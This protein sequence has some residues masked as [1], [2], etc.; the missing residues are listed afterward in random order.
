MIIPGDQNDATRVVVG[1]TFV[2]F[3]DTV[4][5]AA[6][7]DELET[8]AIS[9]LG[10]AA[11]A[12]TTPSRTTGLV[13]GRVQS[14]KTLSYESVIA[15]ARDNGF[16]LVVVISGIS[17]PLLDQGVG[18][19]KGDLTKAAPDGWNFLINAADTREN[20]SRME[21]LR[22]NWLDPETP[23]GLRRTL[24][25]F[26]LKNH[27]RIDAFKEL[28][29]KADWAGQRV[30]IIDD[31]AD[32]ASLNVKFR[33][34]NQSTTYKN[35]LSLRSQ[36][37][38]H[39]YLQYTA[40]PQAPLLVSIDDALSPDFVQVI[41]PG[42]EYVGGPDY[43]DGRAGTIVH[44][45]SSEDLEL[46]YDRQGPPP[47]S[48]SKALAEFVIGAAHVLASGR[49][50]T[51]SMLI[52]PS[53]ET[54]P[55]GTFVSWTYRI[56]EMWGGALVDPSD[57]HDLREAFA[58]AWEGLAATDPGLAS[59]DDCWRKVRFVL[60]N[61]QV[62]EMNTRDSSPTP[63]IDWDSSLAFILVGGQA[64]D[65]GFTVNGLAVT[66]MPRDPGQR[67][68]DTIQQRARFF[69][70]KRSYFGQ[71]RV[72]LDPEL[73]H[74]FG[75]YVE[76]EKHMLRS[77]RQIQAKQ[78]SLKEW[79]RAFFLS[80]D[81]RPT[82]DSVVSLST[83]AVEPGERWIYDPRPPENSEI[84]AETLKLVRAFVEDTP[85]SE[86][87]NGHRWHQVPYQ[88]VVRLL[89]ESPSPS[90]APLPQMNALKLQLAHLADTDPD[91]TA[92][93][94]LMRP[95]VDGYRTLSSGRIQPFQGRS[96]RY[97]GDRDVLVPGRVAIQIH[98][99]EVRQDQNSA[100]QTEAVIVACHVPEALANK[101]LVE[102]EERD[103][104]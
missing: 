74:L 49:S 32:Q 90:D 103:D 70:Y 2:G 71:C 98:H 89:D 58:T 55:H 100:A 83:I 15:L 45:L 81:M 102:D 84:A 87:D 64:L 28:C 41:E 92:D 67:M 12:G 86:D 4:A 39:A 56:L 77:L 95:N 82:R 47:P 26:L 31:E 20:L 50:D 38:S 19:L 94:I 73:H 72:Y 76:H 104:Q 53:R 52:H 101:W 13:V 5:P 30:L 3:L 33:R 96:K 18:R 36:F 91:G 7:R 63:T 66:Y 17:N 6:A 75:A 60:R 27:R 51:R 11:V 57:E 21:S 42:P 14:G 29:A 65:R 9:I 25:C 78:T 35:I 88:S 40:T 43:F 23:R 10:R 93:V 61:I 8:N 37:P 99:F 68:A 97:S 54:E 34:G 46:A 24:V 1:D 85:S 80:P 16:S 48:L 44:D 69:G 62:I 79:K 22:D 59:F